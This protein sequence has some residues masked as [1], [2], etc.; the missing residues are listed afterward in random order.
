MMMVLRW[1]VV[2]SFETLDICSREK[3]REERGV[4][5]LEKKVKSRFTERRKK[6][7]R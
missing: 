5:F 6:K 1:K 4:C 7:R 3:I 2:W